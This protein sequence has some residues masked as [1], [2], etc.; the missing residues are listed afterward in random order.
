MEALLILL[1]EFLFAPLL[2]LLTVAIELLLTLLAF[3]ANFLLLTIGGTKKDSTDKTKLDQLSSGLLKRSL[4]F[5]RGLTLFLL[6]ITLTVFLLVQF[7]FFESSLR[8]IAS[9]LSQMLH[10]TASVCG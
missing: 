9:R 2:A 1:G 10:L 7:V 4:P 3:I 5:F 8:F 6:A